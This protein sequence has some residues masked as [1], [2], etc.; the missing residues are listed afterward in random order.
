MYV[1]QVSAYLAGHEA[2]DPLASPLFGS[3]AGLPPIRIH[4]GND[5]VLRD[6]SLRFVERAVA[7]GY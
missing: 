7:T 2:A 6:D 1:A 4:V 3:F 5:E